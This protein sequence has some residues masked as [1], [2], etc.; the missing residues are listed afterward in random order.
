MHELDILSY[1]LVKYEV[2]L[3]YENQIYQTQF[4]AIQKNVWKDVM[5]L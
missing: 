2:P 3:P 5:W 1:T 4:Q